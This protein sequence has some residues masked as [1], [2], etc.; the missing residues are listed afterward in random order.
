MIFHKAERLR[1]LIDKDPGAYN[2]LAKRRI[3]KIVKLRKV[4]VPAQYVSNKVDPTNNE[5]YAS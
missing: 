2:A 4:E 5:T 3:C 1:E